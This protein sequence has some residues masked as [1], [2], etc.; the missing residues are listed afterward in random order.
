[1]I[2]NENVLDLSYE[3]WYVY[4]DNY[5]T[6]EEK[7]TKNIVKY[8]VKISLDKFTKILYYINNTRITTGKNRRTCV[9]C[10]V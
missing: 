7:I 10:K 8:L 4:N 3:P 2:A 1:M 6:G 5:G 9:Y